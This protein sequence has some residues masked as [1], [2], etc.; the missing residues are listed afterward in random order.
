MIR[1][2]CGTLEEFRGWKEE[3]AVGKWVLLLRGGRYGIVVSNE[4]AT[5]SRNVINS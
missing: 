3:W 2:S 4:H 5:A 1:L